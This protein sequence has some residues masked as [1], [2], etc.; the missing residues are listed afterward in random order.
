MKPQ[1]CVTIVGVEG[2]PVLASSVCLTIA[3]DKQKT[4]HLDECQK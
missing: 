4:P 1:T 3:M 2:S